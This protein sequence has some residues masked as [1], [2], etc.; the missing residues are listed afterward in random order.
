MWRVRPL[1]LARLRAHTATSGHTNTA[2]KHSATACV[3]AGGCVAKPPFTFLCAARP[4]NSMRPSRALMS[5]ISASGA[6][7]SSVSTALSCGSSASACNFQGYSSCET[8]NRKFRKESLIDA[9]SSVSIALSCESSASLCVQQCC[10]FKKEGCHQTSAISVD[11]ECKGWHMSRHTVP[12]AAD[13]PP[14]SGRHG[15]LLCRGACSGVSWLSHLILL[16]AVEHDAVAVPSGQGIMLLRASLSGVNRV[17]HLV[18]LEV[19]G[20]DAV[21]AQLHATADGLLPPHDQPQQCALAGAVGA[22]RRRQAEA[23]WQAA[24]SKQ[25][26]SNSMLQAKRWWSACA[27]QA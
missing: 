10:L 22:C 11:I 9:R 24:Q 16:E 26:I 3:D 8:R 21:R 18:L 2:R 13:P 5:C 23:S 25:H 6:A 14:F 15:A 20:H 19:V 4:E 17:S 12:C 7:R 1:T 27:C